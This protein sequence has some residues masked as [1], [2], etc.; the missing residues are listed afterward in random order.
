[1]C[2]HC[3]AS[4]ILQ[5]LSQWFETKH[6]QVVKPL[7]SQMFDHELPVMKLHAWKQLLQYAFRFE[8]LGLVITPQRHLVAVFKGKKPVEI[9]LKNTLD[10][11]LIDLDEYFARAIAS[12]RVT[13]TFE[14][15]CL[16]IPRTDAVFVNAQEQKAFSCGDRIKDSEKVNYGQAFFAS[17]TDKQLIYRFCNQFFPI[18]LMEQLEAYAE[19]CE[20]YHF[21]QNYIFECLAKNQYL[22]TCQLICCH[23]KNPCYPGIIRYSGSEYIK[24]ILVVASVLVIGSQFMCVNFDKSVKSVDP[25]A[26]KDFEHKGYVLKTITK[27]VTLPP[28][29]KHMFSRWRLR[30]PE[31]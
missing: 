7:I 22:L 31:A 13:N 3:D 2:E 17:A 9:T 6:Q 10:Q 27:P 16:D 26:L 14:S 8:D 19:L 21:T 23:P 12:S 11:Q 29:K 1:M 24:S 4:F 18:V 30:N 15:F 28:P 5:E 20:Y 25:E